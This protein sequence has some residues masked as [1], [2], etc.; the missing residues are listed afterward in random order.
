MT[1]RDGTSLAT[2]STMTNST[3][4]PCCYKDVWKGL[5]ET[6][7][8]YTEFYKLFPPFGDPA[9]LA[10]HLLD[11]NPLTSPIGILLLV[12]PTKGD[13]F[14]VPM[15]SVEKARA[16]PGR[17]LCKAQVGVEGDLH[18]VTGNV[19]FRRVE[20][21]A[22]DMFTTVKDISVPTAA[23]FLK[24]R[25]TASNWEG[26]LL[27]PVPENASDHEKVSVLK[28][29]P[30]PL[31]ILYEIV[32]KWY[33]PY[34]L[35]DILLEW[36]RQRNKPIKLDVFWPLVWA[37]AASVMQQGT[38]ALYPPLTFMGGLDWNVP[39]LRETL[40]DEAEYI[41][42]RLKHDLPGRY[43]VKKLPMEGNLNDLTEAVKDLK[44]ATNSGSAASSPV[45]R[46][47]QTV[48]KYSYES[49]CKLQK[50]TDESHFSDGFRSIIKYPQKEWRSVMEQA[51]ST[52][53]GNIP[54]GTPVVTKL[55]ADNV[56][57]GQWSTSSNERGHYELCL[58]LFGLVLPTSPLGKSLRERNL[59]QDA[60]DGGTVQVNIESIKELSKA[61][62]TLIRDT[63]TL[64][65][66]L[67]MMC[68]FLQ[69]YEEVEHATAFK[70]F[71][72]NT[73]P[74]VRRLL[75][76][77]GDIVPDGIEEPVLLVAC[78]LA[79]IMNQYWSE[80]REGRRPN[81]PS[82]GNVLAVV[83]ENKWHLIQHDIPNHY[84][85]MLNKLKSDTSRRGGV[86]P[87]GNP[88]GSD[89]GGRAGG[90]GGP[91]QTGSLFL[92]LLINQVDLS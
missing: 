86:A 54:G 45:E 74:L 79:R 83:D 35:Y 61:E 51:L 66:A 48:N 92:F 6:V 73:W 41:V 4:S 85:A 68:T 26:E 23:G 55:L 46:T 39:P 76:A 58:S 62:V 81:L 87:A 14:V 13:Y 24:R 70:E 84:K 18:P 77:P 2:P 75:D 63:T 59:V 80:L 10:A 82:Y 29:C 36:N 34:E 22:D 37:R 89:N 33:R 50:T 72:Y 15:H 71:Y 64:D 44:V 5:G 28:C 31:E 49:L 47:W 43:H 60:V 90:N 27:K 52:A 19:N 88:G 42:E 38:D 17:P 30:I 20:S 3:A 65:L 7:L 16:T 32:G 25:E 11:A 8:E 1:A 53:G 21:I 67:S 12:A 69:V 57:R 9:S 40:P 78:H 91:H 56:T